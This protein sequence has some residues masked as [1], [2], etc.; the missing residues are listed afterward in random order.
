MTDQLTLTVTPRAME[1]ME[2]MGG[3]FFLTVGE[4]KTPRGPMP[5]AVCRI[6]EPKEEDRPGFERLSQGGVTLWVPKEEVF[7]QNNVYVDLYAVERM[8]LPVAMTCI[9]MPACEGSCDSCASDCSSRKTGG[10][11]EEPQDVSNT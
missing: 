10:E 11:A 8:V 3:L 5:M 1:W 4:L 7:I 9:L 2:A 6:G